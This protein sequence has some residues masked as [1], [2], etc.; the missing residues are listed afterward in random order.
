MKNT[1]QHPWEASDS[2]GIVK[3]RLW[4]F[5]E[6]PDELVFESGARLGP[7]TLAFETYGQLD[8]NRSNAILITHAFT[9]DAHAAGWHSHRDRKPGWWDGAIGPGKAFDTDRYFV[10]CSNVIGG[11]SG[12]TGPGS[13]DP[14]RGRPFA[15][16]FPLV[17]VRDMVEVQRRLIDFLGIERLLAVAGGS[18]GGMQALQWSIDHPDRIAACIPMATCA[19]ASAQIIALDAVGRQAI[20]ADPFWNRGE[21]YGSTPPEAGLSVARM[22]G[23]ITY[24]SDASMRN[25][26]GR[27]LQESED[28]GSRFGTD[29]AV[30]SYLR[31]RGTTFP[32][33]FDA[34]C[35]L[36]LSQAI[37]NFDLAR[38]C[39]SLAHAFRNTRA[40]FL[41]LSFT[42]DWLYP[43]YHSREIVRALLA[44]GIDVTYQDVE[45]VYG[46]DAFLIE[47]DRLVDPVGEFLGRVHRMERHRGKRGS[48]TVTR[49]GIA[50]G[51][52]F[53][54][55]PTQQTDQTAF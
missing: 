3:K 34:N 33:R 7:V 44:G 6:P 24:M 45:S 36:Y 27:R 18:M 52:R 4:T 53:L 12:S 13:I 40:K 39:P 14:V 37:D 26:F 48:Q 55:G 9:G 25:K 31:Y 54:H 5:G 42:S 41:V 28:S 49:P 15:L 46:H 22:V 21:Y 50:A 8:E 20:Y 47:T 29:F 23:H 2:V 10:I 11:C 35:Y 17:T 30:E 1:T 51:G 43:S 19:R 38:G 32:G 16:R